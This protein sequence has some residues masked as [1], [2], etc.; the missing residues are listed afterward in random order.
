MGVF[1]AGVFFAIGF[2]AGVCLTGAAGVSPVVANRDSIAVYAHWS[3]RRAVAS[4]ES[5][6]ASGIPEN[7]AAL[8]LAATRVAS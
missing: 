2:F 7:D 4:Q 5:I 3:S 8:D 1:G 6:V